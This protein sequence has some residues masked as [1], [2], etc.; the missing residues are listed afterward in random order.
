MTEGELGRSSQA[1]CPLAELRAGLSSLK[2]ERQHAL[3][4]VF[5]VEAQARPLRVDAQRAPFRLEPD[6]AL[7]TKSTGSLRSKGSRCV[8]TTHNHLDGGDDEQSET[9][10]CHGNTC[11]CS[12]S[13]RFCPGKGC[14]CWR[15]RVSRRRSGRERSCRRVVRRWS[16]RERP[17][18]RWV[19]RR[20]D[21]GER[22]RKPGPFIR[23]RRWGPFGQRRG[24]KRF[25]ENWFLQHRNQWSST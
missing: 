25:D 11:D 5:D 7:H 20:W 3:C 8:D 23:R 18:Q 15:R 24:Q 10:W 2:M 16:E 22:P 19:V 13:F 17:R 4:V 14:R 6:G 21:S 1:G 9:S 12:L